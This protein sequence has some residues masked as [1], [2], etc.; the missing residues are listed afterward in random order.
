MTPEEMDKFIKDTLLWGG[1]S[2]LLV[3]VIGAILFI[4]LLCTH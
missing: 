4:N 1:I 2:Y 3:G